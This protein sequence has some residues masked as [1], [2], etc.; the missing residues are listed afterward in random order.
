[1]IGIS[2]IKNQNK[3]EQLP[4]FNKRTAGF[5]IGKQGRNL[6]RKLE[7]LTKKKYL[8]RLKKGL[9]VTESQLLSLED[10]KGYGEYIA[11][12]LRYP[13]YLSLEY[14]LSANNLIPEAVNV[15]TS[16]TVKSSRVYSND[17]GS[18][19]YRNIKSELF[20]GFVKKDTGKL[21]VSVATLAKALFDYL[22]LKRNLN[23]NLSYDLRDG[24]RINWDL[25][26]K[27]DLNEFGKYVALSCSKKMMKVNKIIKKI[28]ND[29]Q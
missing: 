12:I 11:N 22:Y 2:G 1:M 26:S 21:K 14:V 17:L 28:K 19:I 20:V 9:Y 27:N 23:E 6:D 24:L 25:F 4:Y 15:W 13:S 10:K 16:I 5:L 29:S 7:Q 8:I 3:L 18:Y